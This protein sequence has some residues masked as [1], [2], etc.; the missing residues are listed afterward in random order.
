MR[1][2][3]PALSALPALMMP[4]GCCVNSVTEVV[5]PAKERAKFG[6]EAHHLVE[7]VCVLAD[8]ICYRFSKS[9]HLVVAAHETMIVEAPDKI[10]TP[11]VM[12]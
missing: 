8:V 9:E 3:T 11:M 7:G 1:V 2:I 6:F 4:A 10:G 5:P 12:V